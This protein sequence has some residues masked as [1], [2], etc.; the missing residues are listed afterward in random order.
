MPEVKLMASG[1][2]GA[3]SMPGARSGAVITSP[4]VDTVMEPR[5]KLGMPGAA[6]VRTT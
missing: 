1:S 2:D 4:S 3:I 5:N 6:F